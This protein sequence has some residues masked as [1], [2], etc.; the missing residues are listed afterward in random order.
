MGAPVPTSAHILPHAA[1][2]PVV[3]LQLAPAA[4]SPAR[5]DRELGEALRQPDGARDRR[6]HDRSVHRDE[7]AAEAARRPDRAALRVARARALVA[8]LGRSRAMSVRSAT[9]AGPLR[10]LC[11]HG[12]GGSA[13]EFAERTKFVSELLPPGE[14]ELV[15]VDAPHSLGE[16]R[17]FAWWS[18]APDGARS[19]EAERFVGADESLAAIRTAWTDQPFDALLGHSQGAML[20]AMVVAG[21]AGD[22]VRP[23][24]AIMTGAAWPRPFG[25]ALRAL[26]SAK[27]EEAGYV[28]RWPDLTRDEMVVLLDEPSVEAAGEHERQA[29]PEAT[30]G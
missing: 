9:I 16:G 10:V 25:D 12:K 26:S 28:M 3:L 20:A 30:A 8:L 1:K 14:V 21:C 5:N 4:P 23:R 27:I 7:I 17:G 15:C 13:R 18:Q 2:R 24:A 11:L 19:Y 22:A 6:D 29:G